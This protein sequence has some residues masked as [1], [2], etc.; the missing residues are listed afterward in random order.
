M[1]IVCFLVIS[2]V[3]VD[4]YYQLVLR[5]PIVLLSTTVPLVVHHISSLYMEVGLVT[6]ILIENQ[7]ALCPPST[8]RLVINQE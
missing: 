2:T 7:T 6:Q 3:V 8:C 1:V 5:Q 4:G